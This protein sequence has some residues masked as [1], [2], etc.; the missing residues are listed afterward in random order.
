MVFNVENHFTVF[1]RTLDIVEV[2]VAF[3]DLRGK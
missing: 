1:V 2:Y 3:L